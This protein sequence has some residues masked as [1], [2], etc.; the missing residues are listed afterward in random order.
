MWPLSNKALR[1]A[2]LPALVLLSWACSPER[3]P[4]APAVLRVGVLPD[5]RPDAL[6]HRYEPLIAHLAKELGQ[7]VRLIIPEDYQQLV[8]RF[9]SGD[10]DLAYFGGATY[11][12]AAEKHG[13]LPLVMRDIDAEFTSYFLT[14]AER[15]ETAVADFEGLVFAFGSE[16][17][18]SGHLMPRFFLQEQDIAPETLFGEVRYSGA[19]DTTVA[20]VRDGQVDL[21][22]AN[23]EVVN[24]MLRDGRLAP[25]VLRIVWETPPYA[26]YVW[27]LRPG[28]GEAYTTRLQDAFM[29]LS[30]ID[31]EAAGILRRM[32]AGGFL[33]AAPGDFDR[34]RGVMSTLPRFQAMIAAGSR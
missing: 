8:T 26:D 31:E 20:W 6:R 17:S 2:L 14:R 15:P 29:G 27:A 5:E 25:G 9:G 7:E 11:V 19:H 1:A 23:A 24:A 3:G 22:A 16:L 4:A 13:A 30:Q 10:L 34:L 12:A 32:G 33:P 18:T 21:G 28:L